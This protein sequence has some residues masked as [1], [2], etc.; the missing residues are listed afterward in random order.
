MRMIVLTKKILF[1]LRLTYYVLSIIDF[2]VMFELIRFFLPRAVLS[3][4]IL[5]DIIFSWNRFI[6]TVDTDISHP[7][8]SRIDLECLEICDLGKRNSSMHLEQRTN[9]SNEQYVYEE[10]MKNFW[11][12]WYWFVSDDFLDIPFI[13]KIRLTNTKRPWSRKCLGLVTSWKST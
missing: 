9:K 2:L 8:L 3:I 12:W 4:F 13:S 11:M 10:E 5:V 1:I 7:K 6:S